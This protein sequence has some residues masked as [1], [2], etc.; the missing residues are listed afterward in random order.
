MCEL[1]T[2]SWRRPAVVA[3]MAEMPFSYTAASSTSSYGILRN[4]KERHFL[5]KVAKGGPKKLDSVNKVGVFWTALV[6]L[7]LLQRASLA[8][9][10]RYR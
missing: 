9:V 2:A 6:S 8:A 4:F 5:L 7:T 10:S 3:L 1:A